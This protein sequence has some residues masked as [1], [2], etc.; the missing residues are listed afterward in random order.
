[1]EKGGFEVKIGFLWQTTLLWVLPSRKVDNLPDGHR[2]KEIEAIMQFTRAIA[3][4]PGE[5]LGAGL[6]TATLGA[7]DYANAIEQF[8]AYIDALMGCGVEVTVLDALEGYPDAHFVEDTAVVTPDLAVITNPGAESRKGEVASV[9]AALKPFRP[10]VGIQPPGTLDGG[11]VLMMG[12]HFLIGLSDRTNAAGAKQLGDVV[13]GFG[14]TRA[15]VPVDAGLHFKSSVNAVGPDTLL[16][17]PD[18]ADHP[19]L[20]GYQR[21]VIAPEE[22]YAG[23]T[24]LV[25]GRLIM[26]AGYPDTRGKLQAL[27]MPI[28]ELDTSEFRKMDGGLTCLSLRF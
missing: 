1:V 27:D 18:F 15:T 5:N 25:N 9:E 11:D 6:T 28:V 22:A 7:P 10:T 12:R 26:P 16:V 21:I 23:N 8:D 17:T 3:R 4:R 14:C 19:A 24:L 2:R 20:A 13:A